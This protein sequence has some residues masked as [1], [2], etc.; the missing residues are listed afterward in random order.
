MSGSDPLR[1]IQAAREFGLQ[2][3]DVVGKLPRRAPSGLRSQLA[4]SAQAVGSIL[5][6]GFGRGTTAEK[7]HYSRMANGSLEESQEYLRECINL[8]LIDRKVFYRLW[9]LSVVTSRMLLSLIAKLED[10]RDATD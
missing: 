5:A 9:N 1:V 2:V 7:I 4:E 8:H 10:R 6:E 3:L